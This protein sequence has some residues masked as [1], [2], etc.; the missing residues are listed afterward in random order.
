MSL[1]TCEICGGHIPL[2]PDASNR[3][4]IC[5]AGV[6]AVKIEKNEGGRMQEIIL[7]RKCDDELPPERWFVL[8]FR[9]GESKSET[10]CYLGEGEWRSP[11]GSSTATCPAYLPPT[12][13]MPLPE[14]PAI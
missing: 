13:W 9:E 5:G 2:G 10:S 6:F 11:W 7:W 8:T 12:H 4:E 3:C 1:S 14:P